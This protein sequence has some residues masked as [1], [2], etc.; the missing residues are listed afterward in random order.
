[1]KYS[2]RS[3]MIVVLLSGPA[4]WY[5][6]SMFGGHRE[7]QAAAQMAETRRKELQSARSAVQK[8]PTLQNVVGER[9]ARLRYKRDWDVAAEKKGRCLVPVSLPPAP[10]PSQSYD[11]FVR[12]PRNPPNPSAPAPTPPKK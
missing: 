8:S 6:W 3:L 2:L 10:S 9:H 11:S 4:V 1:M 7:A 5:A 12:A